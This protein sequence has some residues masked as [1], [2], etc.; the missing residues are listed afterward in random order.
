MSHGISMRVWNSPLLAA[1]LAG[2]FIFPCSS[3]AQTGAIE[4]TVADPSGAVLTGVRVQVTDSR[5]GAAR[6]L[7]TDDTGYYSA[8]ALLPGLYEIHLSRDGFQPQLRKGLRLSAGRTLRLDF[9]LELGGQ[10]EAIVVEAD[11]PMVSVSLSDWGGRIREE[12]LNALPLN[13]RNL[14]EL[15]VLEPGVAVASSA[16]TGLNDGFGLKMAVKGGRPAQNSFQ[17]DGVFTNDATGIA[18]SSATGQQLGIE[19]V[20]ELHL[21][22]DPYSAEYGR[23]AGA[24][25]TA[26]SKSGTNDLHGSLFNYFRNSALDAKN[27]F[28]LRD[29]KIPPLR[30][31]Q[32]GG[33]LSGPLRRDRAFF[34]FNYEGVRETRGRTVRP[35]VPSAE[36]REGLLPAS[37]GGLRQ[38][39]IRPEVRP[40][41]ALYP[42]P[43]GQLFGDGTGE[44]VTELQ[45]DIEDN[46]LVT[47]LDLLPAPGS[48]LFGRYT[49]DR[50]SSLE[51]DPLRIFE[52]LHSSNYHFAQ[53]ELQQTHSPSTISNFR[54]GF[55]RTLHAETSEADESLSRELAFLPGRAL[56]SIRVTGLESIGGSQV[57]GRPRRFAKNSYQ[58]GWQ[59]SHIAGRHTLKM[60]ASADRV[61]FNQLSPRSAVGEYRFGSI[62]NFFAAQPMRAEVMT[63]DS[64]AARGW[65]LNQFF[66]YI[67]DEFRVNSRLSM[68][69]GVRYE[70]SS[71]PSEVNGKVATLP[72]YLNDTGVTVGG[73]L[74]RNPARWNFAPRGSLAWDP[75]GSGRTVIRAGGGIF[76]ELL[77]SRLLSIAGVRM[78]PFYKRLR[79]R[80]APFPNLE[81]L[82]LDP[83]APV[84]LDTVD[85]DML[86]PYVA[87][88][89][90]A[91]ER[92]F[93]ANLALRTAYSG[94]RGVHLL[95]SIANVNPRV[96]EVMPDG[97]LRFPASGPRL[98][99]ALGDITMRRPHFNSFY[100]GGSIELQRR[101]SRN[102]SFQANY[103]FSKSIDD[104]SADVLGDYLQND[105]VPTPLNYRENRGRSDF[106]LTHVAAVT[107]SYQL[108]EVRGAALKPLLGGWQVHS[109]FQARSG[110]PFVPDVGF[111]RARIGEGA[112]DVGQRPDL[113]AAPGTNLIFGR[114]ERWFDPLA[115][116]LPEPGYY[117][118]LGRGT[119]NG[120]GLTTLDFALH[121][122]LWKTER[123]SV[124][125]R[126]E[127]FNVTNRANFQIPEDRELFNT[128]GQRVA[129]AGRITRTVAPSRQV[130]LALRWEF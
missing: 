119:L 125:L 24:A 5:T 59:M 88:W 14:F 53:L 7:T 120:P 70:T 123:Q 44:F 128:N 92:Q 99:P 115:F 97:R 23:T 118:N 6:S 42:L 21:V 38:V 19:S 2:A 65:R 43:N 103:T 126:A 49:F 73:A 100:H 77:G 90:L 86:Q 57:L 96:P 93:G 36:A 10:R 46:F 114:P 60:G 109:I 84:S 40:Y 78:P 76:H 18:P 89:Q 63:L 41:L 27:F 26:V 34:L 50:A 67:Q 64:D 79:P 75:F 69:L 3:S 82:A 94:A 122:S 15:S 113:I 17:I 35:I 101:W 9:V 66:G 54:V 22:T 20:Q 108:P 16:D 4:G 51:P 112:S 124:K 31:N 58:F 39:E 8:L 80:A 55:S 107:L 52:F 117:G 81:P 11:A 105:R 104:T 127:A 47:R 61:Q 130:Q 87:R 32:F 129:S 98:N 71:V 121:K 33:L 13:G 28:D 83:N 111:D 102:F 95:G 1:L 12:A 116:A 74:Y 62:A 106:D 85:Y 56:G 37:G 91:V 30:R 110:P 45:N 29:E 25:M 48:R 68:S 72:D